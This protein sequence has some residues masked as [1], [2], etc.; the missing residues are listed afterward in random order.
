[1]TSVHGAGQGPVRWGMLAV[2][3]LGIMALTLNWF[4]VATAFPLIGAQ[5]KVGLGSLSLLISLYIVGYGLSHI[6]GGVLATRVGM[7]KTIAFGLLVQGL[8]GIMSGLSHSYAELACFR[9]VSGIGGSVFIAAATAAF[10]FGFNDKEVT[11]ALGVSGG[12]VFSSGAG[13]ALYVWIYLQR[14]TSWH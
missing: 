3:S 2:I 10:V 5:F 6:P 11:L 13:L 12:A 8:A 4:D 7:K 9:V 1:M 14:A